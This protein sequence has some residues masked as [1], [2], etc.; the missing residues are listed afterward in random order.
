MSNMSDSGNRGRRDT[1]V[2]NREPEQNARAGDNWVEF[3]CGDLIAGRFEILSLLGRGGMGFVY[4]VADRQSA[5]KYAMK[6][7]SAM[8][9]SER[10]RK[11]FEIEAKATSLIK[12]PNVVEFHDLV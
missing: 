3:E 2:L 8:N 1:P 10:V 9:A 4:L 7:V 11:R 5:K 6:T 12:H